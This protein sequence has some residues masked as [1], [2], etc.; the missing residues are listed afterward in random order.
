MQTVK[1]IWETA[2]RLAA[3]LPYCPLASTREMAAPQT[4]VDVGANNSQWSR[5]LRDEW[6]DMRIISF[7]PLD[8][9]KPIGEVH[10]VALGDERCSVRMKSERGASHI[11]GDGTIPV[12]RFD[13]IAIAVSKP[14]ILKIDCENYTA[15]ALRGFGERIHRFDV[16]VVEM[17]NHYPELSHFSN[18]Q[19][20]IWR[21][22]MDAGFR[23]ARVV[24][25]EYAIG[26]IPVY[27]IAFYKAH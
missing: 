22:M 27:D 9:F 14:A 16:V 20:E 6:P 8:E 17:W 10:R 15:K 12:W 4:L 23:T 7:E 18:Q 19:C 3:A 5:W 21:F 13:N 1:H 24:D 11:V 26:T 2:V 25:C